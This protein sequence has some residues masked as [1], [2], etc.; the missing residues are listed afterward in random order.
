MTITLGVAAYEQDYT[1]S[2]RINAADEK[3]YAGKKNGKNQVVA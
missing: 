1:T 3:I 2:E